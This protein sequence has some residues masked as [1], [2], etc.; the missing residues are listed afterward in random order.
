MYG[1]DAFLSM[2]EERFECADVFQPY[3]SRRRSPTTE[4]ACELL[5]IPCIE[6]MRGTKM[7]IDIGM[8]ETVLNMLSNL[9]EWL[10]K[11]TASRWMPTLL[12]L[13]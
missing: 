4:R 1:N 7:H 9:H 11:S 5:A 12:G 3:F 10:L 2:S 8:P 13:C 6:A